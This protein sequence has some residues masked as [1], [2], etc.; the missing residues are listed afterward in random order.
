MRTLEV[1]TNKST[2]DVVLAILSISAPKEEKNILL[3]ILLDLKGI[4]TMSN[5]NASLLSL[6]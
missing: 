3:G 5:G 1:R 2:L 4:L 6:V